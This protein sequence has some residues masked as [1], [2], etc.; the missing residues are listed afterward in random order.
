[1]TQDSMTLTTPTASDVLEGCECRACGRKYFPL[2]DY[3]VKCGAR[4]AMQRIGIHGPGKLYSHSIIH[5]APPIFK[6]PY[7]VGWVDFPGEV[8]VLG[9]IF[10]WEDVPLKQGMAMHID[11][12]VIGKEQ[13]GTDRESYVF[14]PLQGNTTDGRS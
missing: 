6:V 14:K 2:R 5:I 4:D 11:Y 9:Q 7:A 8:R 3:C 10:G 1:M 13:D 12:A